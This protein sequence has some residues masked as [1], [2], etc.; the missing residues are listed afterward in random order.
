MLVL[1]RRVGDAVTIGDGVTV[2]V[3]DVQGGRVRLVI[4]AP[5]RRADP[6]GGTR[7]TGAGTGGAR[8]GRL[9]AAAPGRS[10]L[11]EDRRDAYWAG[12]GGTAAGDV[13]G[14]GVQTTGDGQPGRTGQ[15]AGTGA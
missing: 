9:N 12:A 3:A 10:W 7:R 6:P 5:R 11:G 1:T 4:D 8:A 14:G 15:G 2:R 13:A